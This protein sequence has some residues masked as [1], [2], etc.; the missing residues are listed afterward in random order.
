MVGGLTATA[1]V[2]TGAVAAGGTGI[3]ATVA[4]YLKCSFTGAVLQCGDG[5]ATAGGGPGR[6]L[7]EDDGVA[8]PPYDTPA[9]NQTITSPVS[10]P[11][12]P[13]N[14]GAGGLWRPEADLPAEPMD[15]CSGAVPYRKTWNG[16]NTFSYCVDGNGTLKGCTTQWQHSFWSGAF[17]QN[18]CGTTAIPTSVLNCV[19]DGV[20][21]QSLICNLKPAYDDT[22]RYFHCTPQS[23][24]LAGYANCT[25][26]HHDAA[27]DLDVPVACAVTADPS[28]SVPC[29]GANGTLYNCNLTDNR[30]TC[31]GSGRNIDPTTNSLS[32]CKQTPGERAGASVQCTWTAAQTGCALPGAGDAAGC[33]PYQTTVQCAVSPVDGVYNHCKDLGVL[34]A[35]PT[36]AFG[37]VCLRTD[38]KGACIRSAAVPLAAVPGAPVATLDTGLGVDYTVPGGLPPLIAIP[39]GKGGTTLTDHAGATAY[40][41]TDPA[42][43][44]ALLDTKMAA[45]QA[46]VIDLLVRV[47][48]C[49]TAADCQRQL[50]ALTDPALSNKG[51]CP[52]A[53]GN[54]I[55]RLP[56]RLHLSTTAKGF[57]A[58]AGFVAAATGIQFSGADIIGS[59][60]GNTTI[61]PKKIASVG[62]FAAVTGGAI[63]ATVT[64]IGNYYAKKA[65]AEA[66]AAAGGGGGD[67][68]GD[69][70]DGGPAQQATQ[71]QF[72]G[73]AAETVAAIVADPALLAMLQQALT[74][75][76]NPQGVA[77]AQAAGVNV[78][79]AN[80]A[81]LAAQAGEIE[82]A[83][84][85]EVEED[86]ETGGGVGICP[87]NQPDPAAAAAALPAFELV[88]IQVV[89]AN[90][91]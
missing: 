63:L 87:A 74:A 76:V 80:L 2:L 38:A 79:M 5:P 90:C 71:L 19:A 8:A 57:L 9:Y 46:G 3:G 53:I 65:A 58:V 32:N 72:A 23:G 51:R 91:G 18:V 45:A 60:A 68:P 30:H 67:D 61:N 54:C 44:S 40:C 10:Y 37:Q 15:W 4:D 47:G 22:G 17:A 11:T 85:A 48:A 73:S 1:L 69:G 24:Q 31:Q 75:P 56:A 6:G 14:S 83:G 33:P 12:V 28:G 52:L 50:S 49:T 13:A 25:D 27:T 42:G 86:V 59:L 70:G 7:L 39:D 66:E 82:P 16:T 41:T 20:H 89:G 77:A 55:P 26:T 62:V 88:G 78:E 34:S 36:D 29:I 84:A 64:A 81:G 43:C 21:P 35:D